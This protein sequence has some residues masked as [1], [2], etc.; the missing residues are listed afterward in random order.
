MSNKENPKENRE[1]QVK[2]KDYVMEEKFRGDWIAIKGVRTTPEQVAELNRDTFRTN[3]R[4]VEGYMGPKKQEQAPREKPLADR[5]IAE[6]KQYAENN[7]IDLGDA[8]KKADIIA[9][10][11]EAEK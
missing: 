3:V 9:A 1:M 8:K 6:L 7:S 10:I 4:Y 5:T 11:K 2:E